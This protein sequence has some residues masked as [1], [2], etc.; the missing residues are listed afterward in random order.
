MKADLIIRNAMVVTEEFQY[1]ANIAVKDGK[2]IAISAEQFEMEAQ[3]Q[4]DAAGRAVIPGGIDM[5]VHF[6]E[7]G[8]TEW[9]GWE[10]GSR[11]AAAGGVTTVVEMPLNCVPYVTDC[12]AYEL[13]KECAARQ[14]SVDYILWGGLVAD[15]LDQVPLLRE[16]GI[17]CF[18]AF[19]SN[20]GVKYATAHDGIIYEGLKMLNDG[21]AFLGVH[22]ENDQMIDFYTERAKREGKTDIPS[23]VNSRPEISE[24]EA[25][26][27]CLFLAEKTGGNIHIC[28]VATAAGIERI[29]QARK[30]GIHVTAETCPHYLFFT[31]DD[32]IKCGGVLKCAP[33]IR[34]DRNRRALWEQLI[35]GNIDCIASD[36]S[37]CS[38]ELK[39]GK[40]IWSIWGGISGIQNMLNVLLT[41]GFHEYGMTLS[42]IV[43]VF[44]ANPARRMSIYGTKGIIQV[45]ADADLVILDINEE[46]TMKKENSL[47]KNKVSPYFGHQ[48]KG[49]IKQT[50]LRG[51]VIYEDTSDIDARGYGKLIL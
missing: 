37:P 30:A 9:E 48:F 2:I 7:P 27:R 17:Y 13:K 33:P 44:S 1:E 5:H 14:S 24:L 49:K 29:A 40:D 46:W 25:I 8:R 45:G 6:N 12:E 36:H 15:N 42:Q 21:K 16:K 10:T 26:E 31:I 51:R 18:K 4:I 23:Y 47:S 20:S 41:I 43:R 50:I 34:D 22:A 28:H 38:G 32:F 11:A 19:M 39:E 35:R 3:K